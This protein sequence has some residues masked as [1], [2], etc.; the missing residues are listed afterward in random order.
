M[1][2]VNLPKINAHYYSAMTPGLPG[3]R[4]SRQLVRGSR[5]ALASPIP[6]QFAPAALGVASSALGPYRP[7]T[8]TFS[9]R[10]YTVS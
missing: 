10:K 8:A 5:Q 4:G 6:I 1:C 3:G 2:L 7:G 9:S